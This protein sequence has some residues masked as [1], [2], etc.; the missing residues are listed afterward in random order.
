LQAKKNG[1]IQKFQPDIHRHGIEKRKPESYKG[2]KL[3]LD[4]MVVKQLWSKKTT[5][6]ATATSNGFG[7]GLMENDSVFETTAN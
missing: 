6:G 2:E 4:K 7:D 5:T 1:F 3:I